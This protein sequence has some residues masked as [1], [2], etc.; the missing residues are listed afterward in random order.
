MQHGREFTD[1]SPETV[2]GTWNILTYF[3]RNVFAWNSGIEDKGVNSVVVKFFSFC[4]MPNSTFPSK[5]RMSGALSSLNP[6]AL[7]IMCHDSHSMNHCQALSR[8]PFND[9]SSML[10]CC[11]C[12]NPFSSSSAAKLGKILFIGSPTFGPS[13]RIQSGKVFPNDGCC[14]LPKPRSLGERIYIDL[15][16]C[17]TKLI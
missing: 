6:I 2:A 14:S 3:I 16:Y 17:F 8:T 13:T 11:R 5:R 12:V 7:P 10:H 15:G 1:K 4:P 9:S